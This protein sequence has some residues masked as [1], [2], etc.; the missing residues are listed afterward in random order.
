MFKI[1][2]VISD[3]GTPLV[4]LFGAYTP[5]IAVLFVMVG[6]DIVTGIAVYTIKS[7]RV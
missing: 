6:L 2:T 1:P 7:S 4:F 3:F 5:L